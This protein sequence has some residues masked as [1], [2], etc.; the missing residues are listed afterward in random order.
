MQFNLAEHVIFNAMDV[1]LI[2]FLS[3][4]EPFR[5]LSEAVLAQIASS[6]E[7]VDVAQDEVVLKELEPG[8]CAYLILE[9]T[10]RITRAG[11][12]LARRGAGEWIGEIALIDTE[13][14]RIGT[15]KALSPAVLL[16]IRRDDF[17]RWLSHDRDLAAGVMRMLAGKLR[18]DA[19]VQQDRSAKLKTLMD[20][21]KLINSSIET[22]ELIES[23]LTVARRE[24]KVERGTVYFVDHSKGVLW[25]KIASGLDASEIRLPIG[26]GL[27][28]TVA[29]TGE[30]IVLNDAYAD[31]RF[32]RSMDDRSG[33]H[34]RSVLCVPI[35][36][37]AGRV[38]GVLQLLNKNEGDFNAQDLDFLQ[39]LSDYIAIAM[40][41][42]M[43]H[44]SL[45][46]KERMQ[47]EL[48]L[49][50]EI[51]GRLLPAPPQDIPSTALS[52]RSIACYEVGGDY[53][54]FVRLPDGN[55]VLAIGDVSGKGVSAA[56]VMSSLQAALR[57]A[58]PL[59]D[60][61]TDL[62][63]H[64]NS[65]L[66]GM[67]SGSKY[68]TFFVGR[69]DPSTGV[70]R[71][72]NAG[73]QPPFVISASGVQQ[74]NATGMPIGLIPGRS[75]NEEQVRLEPGG[76]L[77]LYTDGVTEAGEGGENE[78]GLERLRELALS[79]RER[80][81]EDVIQQILG[82]VSAFEAGSP[83]CDDKTL[84]VLQRLNSTSSSL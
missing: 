13:G 21:S 51:Q 2:S 42:A 62:A 79:L 9:G 71:Y 40:E 23:I 12:E 4:V 7:R 39:A 8:L 64:L 56:L 78:F 32:D 61:L 1:A 68:V 70:L 73:H 5:H 22:D 24:L 3:N 60:H 36:N 37:Q 63:G 29:A 54:D 31:P 83:V 76:F 48:Q 53:Y 82:E 25:A 26:Q 20:A 16:K 52:A 44:L 84:V 45:V 6:V 46:E 55:L 49:A 77:V 58:A 14:A 50:R 81:G 43:L 33:F 19:E 30:T 15:V 27:A 72:V 38:V 66:H 34:T 11:T 57:M 69:Y 10:V 47:K 18:S 28:G 41:N 80:S 67:T 74:L 35:K 75:W 59:E 17:L 65:L